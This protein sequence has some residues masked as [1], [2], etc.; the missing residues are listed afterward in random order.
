MLKDQGKG[1]TVWISRDHVAR[2]V[3]K[4]LTNPSKCQEIYDP[5]REPTYD[6]IE[7][8]SLA[9]EAPLGQSSTKPASQ[10]T[11]SQN[12]VTHIR[13]K[14]SKEAGVQKVYVCDSK[15]SYAYHSNSSYKGLSRCTH[16]IL[17]MTRKEVQESR[18]PCKLCY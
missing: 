16:Q 9:V 6:R 11:S 4:V 12:T 10:N 15:T 1:K 8:D 14:V 18:S 5:A 2:T 17:S 3:A 13:P 7:Y